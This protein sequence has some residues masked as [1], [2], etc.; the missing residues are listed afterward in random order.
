MIMI[1][2]F[3]ENIS[4]E[5]WTDFIA[6]NLFASPFQT[7]GFYELFNSI[8]NFSAEAIAI[9]DSCSIKALAVIALQ[10]EPGSKGFFSRRG[11]IYGG[12]LISNECPE[13]FDILLREIS[14]KIKRETIYIETRNFSD[15]NSFKDIFQRHGYQYS[16]Y[17]NF[18][19]S[20][21]NLDSISKAVSGSRMRQIK[22]AIRGSVTWK[23]AQNKE[24]VALFYKILLRLY[25]DRIRKPLPPKDFFLKFFDSNLGKYLLVWY[26]N[27]IIGGIMCPVLEGRVIYEFYVCGLDNEYKEQY[28]SIMATWAALEY[29]TKNNIPLFDFMGAGVPGKTYGVRDFKARFGGELVEYGRF[30]NINKPLLYSASRMALRIKRTFGI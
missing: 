12:P 27:E 24:E 14:K 11:I 22:K 28:P 16:P 7:P 25:H 2:Q 29:A 1:A 9:T 6:S 4:R 19:L 8:N 18:R 26:K 30:I 10:R 15:Y 17:L 21:K 3:N 23:E 20:T 13:A 5:L